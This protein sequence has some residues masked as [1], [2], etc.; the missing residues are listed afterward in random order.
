[1]LSHSRKLFWWLFGGRDSAATPHPQNVGDRQMPGLIIGKAFAWPGVRRL[2]TRFQT[3]A[4]SFPEQRDQAP[5]LLI[6]L[7][8]NSLLKP[9]NSPIDSLHRLL[10]VF[11]DGVAG[12]ST[13]SDIEPVTTFSGE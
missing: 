3:P 7:R 1:M 10:C 13:L 9:A 11:G 6:F 4:T 8:S 2:S 5:H 12:R